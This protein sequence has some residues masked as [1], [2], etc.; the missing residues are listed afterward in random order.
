[1]APGQSFFIESIDQERVGSGRY[2]GSTLIFRS[3]TKTGSSPGPGGIQRKGPYSPKGWEDLCFDAGDEPAIA[4][5][6]SLYPGG[7]FHERAGGAGQ[8]RKGPDQ[9]PGAERDAGS[10]KIMHP[11]R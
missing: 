5:G 6:C 2:S 11:A 7:Y 9:R 1:M 4:T 8:E 3:Q 10:T